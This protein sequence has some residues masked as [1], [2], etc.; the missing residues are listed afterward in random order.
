M[1]I[2]LTGRQITTFLCHLSKGVYL[3]CVWGGGMQHF[4]PPT[5]AKDENDENKNPIV[6]IQK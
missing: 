4:P 6:E 5:Q 3:G 2:L 1:L